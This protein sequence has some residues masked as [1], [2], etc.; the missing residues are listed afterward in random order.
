MNPTIEILLKR[1]ESNPEEFK[2]TPHLGRSKWDEMY[3]KY[4]SILDEEDKQAYSDGKRK[5]HLDRF[6]AEVME[7]LLDPKSEE[8][9]WGDSSLTRLGGATQQAGQTHA[10][11]M[12]IHQQALMAQAAAQQQ[13][14]IQKQTGL[15][16]ALGTGYTTMFGKSK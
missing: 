4:E 12:A 2:Y 6:H 5:L 13:S 8:S 1:M 16:N 14:A 3:D 9:L 11:H 10:Q 7:E 15:L